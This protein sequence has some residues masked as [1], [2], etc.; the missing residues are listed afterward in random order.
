MPSLVEMWC[1]SICTERSWLLLLQIFSEHDSRE[2]V[3][4]LTEVPL[5][6]LTV[7]EMLLFCLFLPYWILYATPNFHACVVHALSVHSSDLSHK[8]E[9]T[10]FITCLG[11][12]MQKGGLQIS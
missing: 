5:S 12:Y 6:S 1:K 9:H 3:C 2:K 4:V 10:T 7:L 11:G 8:N